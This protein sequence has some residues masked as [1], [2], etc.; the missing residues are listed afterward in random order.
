MPS[1]ALA[2]QTN[3][4]P[5]SFANENYSLT[6]PSYSLFIHSIS[7]SSTSILCIFYCHLI[8]FCSLSCLAKK[9]NYLQHLGFVP[10]AY[11]CCP[12]LLPPASR[13]YP[14]T[15]FNNNNLLINCC[16]ISYSV[17]QFHRLSSANFFARQYCHAP[18]R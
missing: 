18:G 10:V 1:S 7:F 8:S 12:P 14:Y 6:F 4:I 15:F 17:A 16:V 9:I 11:L 13:Y 3:Y 2:C 5:I